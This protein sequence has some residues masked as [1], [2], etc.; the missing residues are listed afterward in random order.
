MIPGARLVLLGR[1]GAGKG[2]QCTR[3]SRHYVVPHISTGDMLRAAVREGTELGRKAEE[4]MSAGQLL[5][6]DLMVG[7]VDERLERDDTR[8]RGFILDGFPRTV[9]QAEALLEITSPRA[10]DLAVDLEVATEIVLARLATRRVCLDCGTNYSVDVPPKYGNVCDICGGDVVQRRDDTEKAISQRLVLYEAETAPL[11]A[12]F[13]AKGL[14]EVVDGLGHPD[15]V[16]DRLVHTI[17]RRRTS[18]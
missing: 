18:Q 8:T 10:I 17:D 14:L 1:Q 6:D 16:T 15:D 7:I 5:P 3:L 11:I 4:I 12:W 2:T 9:T 13:E